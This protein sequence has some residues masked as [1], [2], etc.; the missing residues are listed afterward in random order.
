MYSNQAHDLADIRDRTRE[1]RSIFGAEPCLTV[2]SGTVAE[3]YRLAGM[4]GAE[5]HDLLQGQMADRGRLLIQFRRKPVMRLRTGFDGANGVVTD[6]DGL[7][8]LCLH[9]PG[10]SY[11]EMDG[12]LQLQI[13]GKIRSSLH[14]A[15][16]LNRPVSDIVPRLPRCLRPRSIRGDAMS[17]DG[18]S[19]GPSTSIR[20]RSHWETLTLMPAEISKRLGV[21]TQTTLDQIPW[22]PFATPVRSGPVSERK[23]A[24]TAPARSRPQL[25]L[26]SAI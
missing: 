5:F 23:P 22:L 7:V 24:A 20:V 25:K 2:V 4:T 26:V 12:A 21:A 13:T 9:F 1:L 3:A 17:F 19:W 11:L 16:T 8:E 10:G 15:G 18:Q 6:R 14:I